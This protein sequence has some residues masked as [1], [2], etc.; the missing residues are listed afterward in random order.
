MTD[1]AEKIRKFIDAPE[2]KSSREVIAF[3]L[4]K[5]RGYEKDYAWTMAGLLIEEYLTDMFRNTKATTN[6]IFKYATKG[7]LS[8]EIIQWANER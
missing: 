4:T 1:L 6:E 7:D 2:I 5:S 3:R 8:G